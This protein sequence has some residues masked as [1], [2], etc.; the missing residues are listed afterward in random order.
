VFVVEGAEGMSA[1][2]FPLLP[3]GAHRFL[4]LFSLFLHHT[5]QTFFLFIVTSP[6]SFVSFANREINIGLFANAKC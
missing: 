1:S 4:L 5:S 3:R 6:D 2:V